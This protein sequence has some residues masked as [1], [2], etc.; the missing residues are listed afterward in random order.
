MKKKGKKENF[1]QNHIP[2]SLKGNGDLL[3][4]VQQTPIQKTKQ[5]SIGRSDQFSNTSNNNRSSKCSI[6]DANN[7]IC[8]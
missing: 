1:Q 3:L 7:D 4:W 2:F 5:K 6:I 8:H